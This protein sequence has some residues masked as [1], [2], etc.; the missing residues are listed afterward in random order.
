M[1]TEYLAKNE[2][3]TQTAYELGFA[4]SQSFAT[5]FKRIMGCTPTEYK[6][7]IKKKIYSQ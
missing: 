5:V 4:S 2:P 6:S 7:N 3:I 1:A